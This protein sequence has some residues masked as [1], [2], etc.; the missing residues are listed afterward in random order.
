MK[1]IFPV[2]SFILF[3]FLGSFSLARHF[4]RGET[5]S[6][7]RVGARWGQSLFLVEKF[8]SA[9]ESERAKMA[10]SLLKNQSQFIGKDPT[11]IRKKLGDPDG[12]YFSDLFPA[13]IIQSAHT[14]KEEA[15]QIVFLLDTKEKVSEIV[16]HKNN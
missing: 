4:W 2:I 13:Y 5:L 6:Q 3:I 14:S 9:S 8:R 7:E 11:E 15:W 12:F 1:K 16:V 10:A